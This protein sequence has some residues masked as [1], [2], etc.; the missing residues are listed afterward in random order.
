MSLLADPVAGRAAEQP[1]ST[2]DRAPRPLRRAGARLVREYAGEVPPG[3]VLALVARVDRALRALPGL[4]ERGRAVACEAAV[5][6][7]LSVRSAQDEG[8]PPDPSS[9]AQGPCRDPGRPA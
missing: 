3:Q 6:V 8:R 1:V 2:H 7:A 9:G 5:R 4:D